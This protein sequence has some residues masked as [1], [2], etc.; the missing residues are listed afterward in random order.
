MIEWTENILL[1]QFILA[2]NKALFKNFTRSF[3]LNKIAVY[4][5]DIPREP[6][7]YVDN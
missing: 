1:L 6:Y 4:N 2:I 7:S 3:Y 5:E